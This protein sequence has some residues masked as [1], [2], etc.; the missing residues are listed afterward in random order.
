MQERELSA[1]RDEL[2]EIKSLLPGATFNYYD[3]HNSDKKLCDGNAKLNLLCKWCCV[4][5][6]LF[7]VCFWGA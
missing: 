3:F 1:M 4:M 6:S 5:F 2:E 7:P